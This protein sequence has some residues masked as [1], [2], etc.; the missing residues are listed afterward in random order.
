MAVF[1]KIVVSKMVLNRT[2]NST[3]INQKIDPTTTK[4]L[5]LQKMQKKRDFINLTDK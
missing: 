1:R 5:T 2:S 3:K 4:N